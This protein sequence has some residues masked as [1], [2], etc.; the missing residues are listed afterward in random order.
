MLR[1]LLSFELRT[2]KWM[3]RKNQLNFL[4][5]NQSQI[6][7]H[8]ESIY[9][10][11]T[12]IFEFFQL[13][14]RGHSFCCSIK[15][16]TGNCWFCKWYFNKKDNPKNKSGNKIIIILLCISGSTVKKRSPIRNWS[17]TG[18]Q[19]CSPMKRGFPIV[20]RWFLP[21]LLQYLNLLPTSRTRDGKWQSSSWLE[22]ETST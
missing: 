8:F 1:K 13:K 4:Y 7:Q 19:L 6:G 22:T 9:K 3:Q 20:L 16:G 5:D 17:W 2:F 14:K 10:S 12:S 15:G 18:W 21:R 11:E